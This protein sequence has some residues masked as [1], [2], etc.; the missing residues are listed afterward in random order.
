MLHGH[1]VVQVDDSLFEQ[2]PAPAPAPH[3]IA[4]LDAVSGS[5]AGAAA[6]PEPPAVSRWAKRHCWSCC[7]VAAKGEGCS[8]S[9][10]VHTLAV[11]P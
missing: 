9:V 7:C 4:T 2:A 10:A 6:A 3:A 8:A 5:G 11:R 1:A